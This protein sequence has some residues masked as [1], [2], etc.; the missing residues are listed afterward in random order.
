MTLGGLLLIALVV[1]VATLCYKV[2]EHS[3]KIKEIK[4]GSKELG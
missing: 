4:E 2:R 3:A 1:T